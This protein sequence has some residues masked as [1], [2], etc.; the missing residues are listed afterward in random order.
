MI[1][2]DEIVSEVMDAA[3]STFGPREYCLFLFSGA[4]TVLPKSDPVCKRYLETYSADLVGVYGKGC[5]PEWIREDIQVAM[6]NE[7]CPIYC[8]EN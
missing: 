7:T 8:Q 2:V 4:W 5:K 3:D 1:D 6:Y